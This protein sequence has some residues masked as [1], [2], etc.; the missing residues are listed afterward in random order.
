M[1]KKETRRYTGYDQ[2]TGREFFTYVE[3]TLLIG[4]EL[5]VWNEYGFEIEKKSECYEYFAKKYL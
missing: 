3:Y 5:R 2:I 1:I 4:K